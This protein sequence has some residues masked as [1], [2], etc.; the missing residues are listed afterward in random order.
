V[1]RHH[2]VALD[3]VAALVKA[4]GPR[5]LIARG[6][7]RSYGDAAQNGGGDV[8]ELC[9]APERLI[10]D[11]S[12]DTVTVSAGVSLDALMRALVPHGYFVPV[13]PG[14]RQ[15][16]VGGA[17]AADIHGKNHH[18]DGSIGRHV[19]SL[20]LVDGT[21]TPRRLDPETMPEEF[22]ATTGGMGL[23]GVITEASL[24]L[25]PIETASMRVETERI[26][27]LGDL[28]A[29]MADDEAHDYSV[30]WIDLLA[31][32]RSLGRAVLT[33]G[34]HARTTELPHRHAAEPLAFAPRE[35]F[36]APSMPS[37]L[38]VNPLTMRAFN[39]FWYRRAPRRRR[40]TIESIASFFHPLDAVADW[41][42]L[43]GRRGLV[44]YQL[45]VPSDAERVL[46]DAVREIAEAG[47]AS[48]LAVL[49]RFGP[50]TPG[51]LSFP[52]AGWTLALDLPATPSLA[53]LLDRL[54]DVVA[55]AGGRVY[56]A[57]D[58][59]TRSDVI[60]RMYPRLDEFRAVRKRLD[61]SGVFQSDLSRRL[62][63]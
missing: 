56:L 11:R 52:I 1:A 36:S 63:L 55:D 31:T 14:T 23:T 53:T 38:A 25:R 15:V 34:A 40:T 4:A 19:R 33:R 60:D 12:A 20:E 17:I 26:G 41:N 58:A 49:K 3:Q 57:K 54:D 39:E 7:G 27:G 37:G 61:P 8:V 29:A 35:R 32:G 51:P 21:G 45:V 48:F 44:Q 5:G 47:H 30:A 16:T 59:R 24:R 62:R 2:R 10:V 22:W 43:Y 46:A 28:L 42:R 13:T 9:R 6:L 50:Q 18:V